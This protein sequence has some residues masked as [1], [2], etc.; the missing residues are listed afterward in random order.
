MSDRASTD[1]REI[2]LAVLSAV[3][4]GDAGLAFDVVSSAMADGVPFDTILFEVIGPLQKD[5]GMRWQLGDFGIAEEH[6]STGAAET[7]VALLAGA[8][9]QPD[10]GDHVVVACAEGDH[11]SLP[12]RMVA[13]YLVWLGYRV[14]FLGAST[15]AADLGDY[16]AQVKPAALVLSCAMATSLPGARDC[17]LAAHDNGVPVVA[18]GRGFGDGTRATRLGADAWLATPQELNDLLRTWQPDIDRTEVAALVRD[19]EASALEKAAPQVL[20]DARANAVEILGEGTRVR[21]AADLRVMVD[22]LVAAVAVG[23]PEI[24]SEYAAWHSELRAA[25]HTGAETTPIIL[26]A[27]HDAAVDHSPRA[28]HY[29]DR[30]IAALS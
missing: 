7:L 10:D 29:L 27:L 25:T 1:L 2:R 12:A 11:H 17:I 18:G 16:L 19:E 26:S 23:D 3:V 8:F 28:A 15:P 13:A 9:T 30:A 6:A 4:E 14:T 24:V 21:I 5:V 22:A 20:L